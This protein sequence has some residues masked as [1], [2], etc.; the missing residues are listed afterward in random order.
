MSDFGFRQ[1]QSISQ[2]Q[3]QVMSQVQIY[4]L[5]MLS[6]NRKEIQSEVNKVVN[7]NPALEIV[8]RSMPFENTRLATS[9]RAGEEMSEKYREAYESSVDTRETLQEHLLSQLNMIRLSED[10]KMLG[11]ALIRNLD[12]N[13]YHLFAPISLLD[14]TRP[15]QTESMLNRL[16]RTIQN[17]EPEGTCCNNLEESLYVQA[18]QRGNAPELALFILNGNLKILYSTSESPDLEK[19]KLTLEEIQ[20]KQNLSYHSEKK[21]I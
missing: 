5:N 3:R 11:E 17:F 20:A 21:K 13:G 12:K 8:H 1:T 2:V 18:L 9:T 15:L 16:I 14:Q 6:L 7:E 10:E 19:I 4:A